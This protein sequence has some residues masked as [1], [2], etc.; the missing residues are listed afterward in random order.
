[1]NELAGPDPN[2]DRGNILSRLSSQENYEKIIWLD[3]QDAKV[4]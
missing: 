2:V 1:M 3:L 4:M